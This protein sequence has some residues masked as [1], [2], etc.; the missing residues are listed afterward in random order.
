MNGLP[1]AILIR[2]AGPP[3]VQAAGMTA[4]KVAVKVFEKSRLV[5][6]RHWKR[7]QK[8][9]EVLKKLNHPSI[10]DVYQ[11]IDSPRRLHV[12]ME[13]VFLVFF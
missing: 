1:P 6:P 4:K 11:V 8:E 5:E 12:I 10:G 13:C 7:V 2:A 3:R 9:I